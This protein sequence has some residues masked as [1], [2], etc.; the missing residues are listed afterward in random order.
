MTSKGAG[1]A[2]PDGTS[3]KLTARPQS[4]FETPMVYARL[5][6][7]DA[8]RAELAARIRARKAE[9]PGVSHSN[10]NG[11]H[12]EADMMAWGGE[13]AR[14]LG[15]T[16]VQV[17]KRMSSVVG[18]APDD[19]AWRLH[20]WANV[21]GPGALNHLHAHPGVLWS[22]VF[23]VDL[24]GGAD[25]EVGGEIVFED[26]RYPLIAMRDPSLR[27]IGADGKPQTPE[28]LLRPVAGDLLVFP[29]WLRHGVRPYRG[30]GERISIAMNI[31]GQRKS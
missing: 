27:M 7:S 4:L 9:H 19:Y 5:E 2:G 13:N 20:M 29:A 10:E 31:D 24:G 6:G 23:Y 1:P 12:S 25:E 21:S 15:E 11:W 28:R 14:L 22:A 8:L 18:G 30:T 16:A 26:P 17:A 3:F